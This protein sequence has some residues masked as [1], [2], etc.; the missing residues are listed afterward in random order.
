[1]QMES[2][3]LPIRPLS[4]DPSIIAFYSSSFPSSSAPHGNHCPTL[5]TFCAFTL[6]LGQLQ[7]VGWQHA[8]LASALHTAR[9]PTSIDA[10]QLV[11]EVAL[12]EAH[13][14]HVLGLVIV[15]GTEDALQEIN[16]LQ[17][18]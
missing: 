4:Y 11:D 10:L 5:C 9:H 13:L 3:P 14:V 16:E 17:L 18:R 12:D 2:D 7:I 15:H 1:M 6:D 8:C